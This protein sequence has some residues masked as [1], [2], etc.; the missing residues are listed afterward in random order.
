MKQLY[1]ILINLLIPVLVVSAQDFR[2][3][4]KV[5][6]ENGEAL[7]G[8]A[9]LDKG[10]NQNYAITDDK[11][12]FNI[13]VREGTVL[14]FSFLNYQTVTRRISDKRSLH[15][16]MEPEKQ[17]LDQAVVIGY[18]TSKKSDLT[19]AVAVIDMEDIHNSPTT[20]VSQTLQGRIAGADIVSGSGEPGESVSIQ[21]RGAR[22]IS[23]GNEP[24]IVVDGV[25]DAVSDLGEL[26]PADIVSIS[27]L[28]DVSSTAIYGARG[29]NGVILVTTDSRQ[30]SDAKYSVYVKSTT[31]IS[32]IA[33][34][35]DLMNATEY[36]DWMN[37]VRLAN[38]SALQYLPQQKGGSYPYYDPRLSGEGTDW[39]KTL[40]QTGIYNEQYARVTVKTN[41]TTIM[42]SFGYNYNRG[43]VIGSDFGRY[44]GSL[45]VDT[46]LGKMVSM[47]VRTR[48]MF[49]DVNRTNAT[50]SGTDTN[51]A[52]YLSPLLDKEST[53]NQY[54]YE[55][56]QGAIFNNPYLCAREITN[57][58]EKWNLHIAPWVQ[59]DFKGGFVWKSSVSFGHDNN[60][61]RVYSPSYLPVAQARRTGG[62]ATRRYWDEIRI[63]NENTLTWTKNI[64]GKQHLNALAGFTASYTRSDYST[65]SGTGF[66]NDEVG[67]YDM[68]GIYNTANWYGS[69]YHNIKTT[70]SVLGR[71]NYDYDR[72]YYLTL[73]VRADGAS[74]FSESN[75]WGFFPA[76]AFRWSIVNEKWLRNATWLNDLS[77]RLS[78]GSS[79]NDAIS[80]YQS[81]P[82]VSSN[83]SSWVFRDGYLL[84]TMP[85][86]LANSHLTWETTTSWDLGLNFSA[87]R[88][89][90]SLE[91]DA[92]YST[93]KNLLLS[94]RNS[95][96]TGY[97]SYMD[98]QGKTRNAGVEVL[99]TTKN[100]QSRNFNWS[101]TLTFS[102]NDQQV[103]DSVAGDEV[104]PTYVNPRSSTEYLYGYKTGY[105][106]NALWGY[107]YEGVWH[108]QDEINRNNYTHTYASVIKDGANGSN[109]GRARYRDINGDGNLDQNDI[110]Y[111]GSSDP[112]AYGG[113][114]N[115]FT[116]WGKLKLG[117]FVTWS[118]GGKMYNLSELYMGSTLGSYNKY[119]YVLD[120]WHPVRNPESNIP[121]PNYDDGLGSDFQ[122]HDA[123][124]LRL[125][126]VSVS[127]KILLSRWS[128]IF[129][130][131][132][133]GLTGENLL[134]L[135]HYNGFDPD[136]S[137]GGSV[138]RLDNGSFPRPRTYT[139]DLQL[140]F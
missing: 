114:Q 74:N 104:V 124:F 122:I 58:A 24:L 130:T 77:L 42:G 88:S 100:I 99:L 30:K 14:E 132:E 106:V 54:G 137:T 71:I 80:S 138:R 29:A 51:A 65:Y 79:G 41:N 55:D 85:S 39:V 9:V 60:F 43:V 3:G 28:K 76:A 59:L 48:Y 95:Q 120:A 129:K 7:I 49:F 5:T 11:G 118:A 50:I 21:I 27:V 69:S 70:M 12:L 119:R 112:V 68:T 32:R 117:V 90:V 140:K 72:R 46:K 135:K 89:R 91:V 22:S 98:N 101:S 83:R 121:R 20:N 102:H 1:C 38:S 57:K 56:S 125:K 107:Q 81:T 10:N 134:L 115:D 133:I 109:I 23:A 2:I 62:T 19:G 108:N 84:V 93:T 63:L 34:T 87:W 8:V 66:L 111:L 31:G 4:G 94:V 73:T 17:V 128:R 36:A 53:W 75:K 18:G 35:L 6:D 16:M 67:Q 78:V 64:A 92:Y 131:L 52:I 61:D 44:T 136:V 96:T 116:F 33:G 15:V 103:L 113:I 47:G 105:P 127:Y 123:S 86:R 45:N 26:N 82:T 37:M 97:S 40:S 110:V 25:M 13:E 139:L 126:T